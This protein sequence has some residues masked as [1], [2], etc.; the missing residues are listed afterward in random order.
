MSLFLPIGLV[1]PLPAEAIDWSWSKFLNL[2]FS[3]S[4]IGLDKK[5]TVCRRLFE[6]DLKFAAENSWIEDEFGIF[7]FDFEEALEI[8]REGEIDLEA[9]EEFE[10]DGVNR[11]LGDRFKV[12]FLEIELL[13]EV[14][15]DR[16]AGSWFGWETYRETGLI[17]EAT[18][19]EDWELLVGTE[20]FRTAEGADEPLA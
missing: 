12:E 1:V 9:V 17:V 3:A 7:E 19:A 13:I 18:E 20:K 5:S 10:V 4:S 8:E 11:G 16:E 14:E 15:E 2:D 6:A